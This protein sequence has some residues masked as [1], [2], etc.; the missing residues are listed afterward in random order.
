MASNKPHNSKLK[1]LCEKS[2]AP[3]PPKTAALDNM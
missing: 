1:G 2:A 3:P